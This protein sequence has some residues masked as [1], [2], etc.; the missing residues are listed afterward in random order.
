MKKTLVLLVSFGLVSGALAVKPSAYSDQQTLLNAGDSVV[1]ADSG[2]VVVKYFSY[3]S[4]ALTNASVALVRIPANTRII[5][6]HISIPAMGGTNK[7][8]VGIIGADGN[9]YYNDT[10]STAD[11]VDLLL[12]GIDSAGGIND[13]FGDF[14]AADY[15][16][17]AGYD[18][19][20]YLTATAGA[21][22]GTWVTN[23]AIVG[24][25]MY[26]KAN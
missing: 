19:D 11:D 4:T 12:D 2:D 7:C 14:A 23:K 8:D 3:T 5:G 18:K 6:G 9:G 16:G 22:D 24:W 17:Q 25:V 13:T 26:L 10:S 21:G 1:M 20:V 15:S